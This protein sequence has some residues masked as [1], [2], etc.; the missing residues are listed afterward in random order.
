M[1]ALLLCANAW[2]FEINTTNGNDVRWSGTS[3]TMQVDVNATAAQRDL[4]DIAETTFY[5]QSS[6]WWHNI[7]DDDDSWAN[8]NGE[9]EIAWASFATIGAVG[10]ARQIYN[11]NTGHIVECDVLLSTDTDWV[12]EDRIDNRVYTSAATGR[13]GVATL[14]HE[15]GHCAGLQHEADVYNIMGTDETHVHVN[16]DDVVAYIGEDASAGLR[17]L[18][19]D[20]SG[21]EELSVSHWKRTGV[22]G[23]YSTHGRVGL[24]DSSWSLMSPYYIEEEPGYWMQKGSAYWPEVTLENSGTSSMWVT[25]SFVLSTNDFITTGDVEL[26]RASYYLSPEGSV[27]TTTNTDITIPTSQASGFYHLGVIIDPDNTVSELDE[28]NNA[29]YLS[30]LVAY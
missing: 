13:H 25:V 28:G 12:G 24:Y 29:V 9:N 18:Y 15:L 14:L 5:N 10:Q 20:W 23:E 27:L 30:S 17:H 3:T 19:G 1:L 22:S 26:A 7:V 21:K 16:A 2:S 6:L 8:G 11:T 4:V